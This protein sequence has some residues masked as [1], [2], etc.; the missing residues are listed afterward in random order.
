MDALTTST[1]TNMG[2]TSSINTS[3]ILPRYYDS[4][5]NLVITETSTIKIQHYSFTI[6]PVDTVIDLPAKKPEKSKA[7]QPTVK[8]LTPSKK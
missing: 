6:A 5:P 8:T 1:N 3:G 4:A 2:T 7:S